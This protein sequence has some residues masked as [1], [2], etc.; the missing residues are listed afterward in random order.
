MRSIA[1]ICTETVQSDTGKSIIKKYNKS[2][3]MYSQHEITLGA[4]G[5]V[6]VQV[7]NSMQLLCIRYLGLQNRILVTVPKGY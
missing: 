3:V 4:A 5:L 1:K 7:S 2:P 6:Q